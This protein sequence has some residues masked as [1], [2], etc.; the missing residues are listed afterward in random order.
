MLF[1]FK[2]HFV[3][4]VFGRSITIQSERCGFKSQLCCLLAN[5]GAAL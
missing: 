5:T 3:A 2:K 1:I 4:G